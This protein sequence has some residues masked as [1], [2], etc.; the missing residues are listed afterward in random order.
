MFAPTHM[1]AAKLT[2]RRA[3]D[4]AALFAATLLAAAGILH[5]PHFCPAAQPNT[6]AKAPTTPTSP[7]SKGPAP[8]I[9]LASRML[10]ELAAS[11]A[12]C[13]VLAGLPAQS[14]IERVRAAAQP[15][16]ELPGTADAALLLRGR[17]ILLLAAIEPDARAARVLARDAANVL[18]K[19]SLTS[20]AAEAL[21]RVSLAQSL[22][23]DQE[24]SAPASTNSD[25]ESPVELLESVLDFPV[26][27]D[28]ARTIPSGLRLEAL[29]FL[30]RI[31]SPDQQSAALRS[32]RE[33]AGTADPIA[34]SLA[35]EAELRALLTASRDPQPRAASPRSLELL[36]AFATRSLDTELA[37]HS[38]R[39]ALIRDKVHRALSVAAINSTALGPRTRLARALAAL[40]RASDPAA[41]RDLEALAT[42]SPVSDHALWALA[43][44]R[45]RSGDA[46]GAAAALA[47]FARRFPADRRASEAQ[48]VAVER[49]ESTLDVALARRMLET[50]TAAD[51]PAAAS[52]LA[53]ALM[54][55]SAASAPAPGHPHNRAEHS[56]FADLDEAL[57]LLDTAGPDAGALRREFIERLAVWSSSANPPRA[58]SAAV[59]ALAAETRLRTQHPALAAEAAAAAGHL[60]TFAK[61][62]APDAIAAF[63][64]ALFSQTTHLGDAR[65][66]QVVTG[67]GRLA[68]DPARA[69]EVFLALKTYTDRVDAESASQRPAPFWHAW[70]E[71]LAIMSARNAAGDRS[72][73][74]RL[75]IRQLQLIDPALGGGP[76]AAQ[77]RAIEKGL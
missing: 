72:S 74:I 6:P 52:R 4:P 56:G 35:D 14:E 7:P 30:V 41:M 27:A 9:E 32:I 51:R 61:D 11:G 23:L 29:A 70:A 2:Q 63:R 46:A 65:R 39:A 47:E 36:E 57:K 49:V 73:Q 21:R 44:T 26:G 53:R 43:E 42:D 50:A 45:R 69:D 67:L 12:D 54:G 8:T 25:A 31:G 28:P 16:S 66:A 59:A 3:V 24:P 22:V 19:F 13:A 76:A 20:T 38:A 55:D 48:R 62:R 71:M 58:A 40:D 33:Q 17:A 18:A 75:R 5:T 10:G 77:I 34:V 60:L 37:G 64:R 1:P 68:S 15:I